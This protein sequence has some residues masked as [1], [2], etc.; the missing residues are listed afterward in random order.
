MILRKATTMGL[1]LIGISSPAVAVSPCVERPTPPPCCADGHCYASPATWG[2]YETRWRPWPHENVEPAAASQPRPSGSEKAVPAFETPPAEEEDRRAPPPTAPITPHE[3]TT[4]NAPAK[5]DQTAPAGPEGRTPPPL[6]PPRPGG[7]STEP[8]G[9]RR[10]LPPYSAPTTRPQT[11]TGPTS[12]ADPPPALPFGPG[13]AMLP[14]KSAAMPPVRRLPA[15]PATLP[16]LAVGV[17]STGDDPPPA[18]PSIL[19]NASN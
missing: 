12:D 3:E 5:G 13:P 10:I 16:K 19:A 14:E 6:V 9:P 17:N 1:L 7:E 15:I 8:A 2:W 18:L 11:G 4:G